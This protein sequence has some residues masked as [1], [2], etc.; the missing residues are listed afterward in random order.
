MQHAPAVDARRELV[1]ARAVGGGGGELAR[2]RE[3][4]LLEA[5]LEQRL[6][7]V[8]VRARVRVR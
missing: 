7:R 4:A 5:D 3:G 8:R 6:L 1:H 2:E